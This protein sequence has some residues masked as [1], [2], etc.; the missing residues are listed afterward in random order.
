MSASRWA[1]T[2]LGVLAVGAVLTL[3][4]PVTAQPS[5]GAEEL[6]R[7][8]TTAGAHASFD[9][10]LEVEWRDH[11]RLHDARTFSHVVDGSAELGSGSEQV[12]AQGAER[13]V[14]SPGNWS[15]VLGS[16]VAS[17]TPPSVDAHWDLATVAGPV[18]AGRAT[19]EVVAR[20]PRSGALRARYDVDR[21]T[22]LLLGR[23]VLDPAGH[24]LR[25]VRYVSLSL[26]TSPSAV[27]APPPAARRQEPAALPALPD[28]FPNPSSV[29]R[30]FE[31]L[32]RYRQPDGTVQ[33][34][35][36]DGLFTLSLFE[37]RGTVDWPSLAAGSDR[38]VEGFRT[39][40]YD[41]P[42]TTAVVWSAHGVTVTCISDAPPDQVDI[43]VRGLLAGGGDGFFPSLAH[44]VLGPFGWD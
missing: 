42:T 38:Q 37:Q 10:V 29:G 3:G 4:P 39:R 16:D 12:L 22:G 19:T 36:G 25:R 8:A 14:G 24:L 18:V 35:Y 13:W 43:A 17:R 20:D 41:A 9:G 1:A 6:L 2:G 15:L 27:P 30:G 34:V 26:T 31:L 5:G 40:R 23:D 33:L 32:G 11:G 7:A 21:A 28:G 44:F